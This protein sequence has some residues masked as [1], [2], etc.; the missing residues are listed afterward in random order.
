[1]GLILAKYAGYK[2]WRARQVQKISDKVFDG[3]KNEAGRLNLTFEDLYIAVLLIYNRINK[4]LPAPHFDPPSK[5]EVK[6]LI[7]KFDLNLDGELSRDE[8]VGFIGKLTKETVFTVS[9]GLI[10]YFAVA[11]RVARLTRKKTEG[12]PYVGK[13]AEKL[14]DPAYAALLTVALVLAQKLLN[15]NR[16]KA[17]FFLIFGYLKI[18]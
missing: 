2:K 10:I 13:V 9:Q 6:T 3:F 16:I 12:V 7:K 15:S 18:V 5:Q 14:P 11:P 8:F 17:L 1:M 4:T